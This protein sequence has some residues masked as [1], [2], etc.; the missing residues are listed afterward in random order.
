[1]VGGGQGLQQ[2][3]T[4]VE[5]KQSLGSGPPTIGEGESPK[6]VSLE[7]IG[8]I[9]FPNKALSLQWSSKAPFNA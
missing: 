9:S 6:P 7:N 5:I 8:K 3:L 1:M 2:L 4:S